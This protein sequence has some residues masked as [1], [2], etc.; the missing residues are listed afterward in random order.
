MLQHLVYKNN[1][2]YYNNDRIS[3]RKTIEFNFNF[4]KKKKKILW[5]K[6]KMNNQI[7]YKIGM[8]WNCNVIPFSQKV[9]TVVASC[10]YIFELNQTKCNTNSCLFYFFSSR[11]EWMT[12]RAMVMMCNWHKV[13][14]NYLHYISLYL[15]MNPLCK[16]D[17]DFSFKCAKT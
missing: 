16:L 4:E 1:D 10:I 11:I 13:I 7:N 8:K 15:T 14:T 17:K 9:I 5:L 3:R 2:N 6:V 12:C